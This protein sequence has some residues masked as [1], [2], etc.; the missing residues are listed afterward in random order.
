[1][2]IQPQAIKEYIIA[3]GKSP[4][5]EWLKSLKDV[6]IRARIRQRVDRFELG[7][8]GDCG[9][10]GDGVY[11]LRLN[12]GPGYRVYFGQIDK[13]TILLLCGGMKRKQ[14]KDIEQA[15]KYWKDYQLED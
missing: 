10:V 7:N 6:K 15:K 13:A 1:M 2:N 5:Q 12:F 14:Q 4:Y 11:E 8:F 9:P 3:E